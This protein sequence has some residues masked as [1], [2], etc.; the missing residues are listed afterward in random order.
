MN[1]FSSGSCYSY[2]EGLDGTISFRS[3]VTEI[4]EWFCHYCGGAVAGKDMKC[5]NCAGEKR[6]HTDIRLRTYAS[7]TYEQESIPVPE[8]PKKK[9][10]L[11]DLR[12]LFK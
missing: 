12:S 5:P 1:Y 7:I 6:E 4:N 9:T 3:S 10:W 8:T 2:A 11:F